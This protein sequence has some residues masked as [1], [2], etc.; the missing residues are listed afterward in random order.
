MSPSS[1]EATRILVIDAGDGQGAG[2][3]SMLKQFG[4]SDI[5]M[6]QS[7]EGALRSLNQSRFDLVLGHMET[8]GFDVEAFARAMRQKESSPNWQTP[9]LFITDVVVKSRLL[10]AL[11]AGVT[12]FV[13][14]A[15]TPDQLRSQLVAAIEPDGTFP[16]ARESL[17]SD[18]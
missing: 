8:P 16:T 18:P 2:L 10:A 4:I 7:A 9:A 14:G 5:T 15:V 17:D 6:T 13:I 11:D 12:G 3:R 1:L